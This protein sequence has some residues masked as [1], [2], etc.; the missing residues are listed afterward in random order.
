MNDHRYD[1]WVF[2]TLWIY[3]RVGYSGRTD[4]IEKRNDSY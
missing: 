3:A 2:F 4:L 1:N